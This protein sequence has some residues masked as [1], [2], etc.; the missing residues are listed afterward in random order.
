MSAEDV[1][2]LV[3]ACAPTLASAV[4]AEEFLD[5]IWKLCKH[6]RDPVI[7]ERCGAAGAVQAVV[8][9][10]LTH[11]ATSVDVARKGC[12]ALGN[13]AALSPSN[14][15][16]IV[17]SAGGL[18]VI[19]VAMEAHPGDKSVQNKACFALNILALGASRSDVSP[20]VLI[21]MLEGRS[22]ELIRTAKVNHP[23]EGVATVVYYADAALHALRVQE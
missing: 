14:T 9:A 5:T 22:V 20:G 6:G 8:S 12:D 19:H 7:K 4:V 21:A 10:M 18:G 3:E 11:A 1:A 16:L 15:E 2:A 17:L 13:L 23:T